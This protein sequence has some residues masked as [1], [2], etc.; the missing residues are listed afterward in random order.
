M[1]DVTPASQRV[2]RDLRPESI[3]P[4]KRMDA[5]P[6]MRVGSDGS[7]EAFGTLAVSAATAIQIVRSKAF[8]VA[9][10][11]LAI[12]MGWVSFEF[13]EQLLGFLSDE[14]PDI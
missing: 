14:T 4:P 12:G 13:G 3:P 9:L 5:E 1:V 7:L 11:I 10:L 6:Y 2:E 8:A